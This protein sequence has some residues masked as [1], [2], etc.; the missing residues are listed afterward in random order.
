MEKIKNPIII[1]GPG[2]SGTTLLNNILGQHP[3]VYWISTYLNKFPKLPILSAL[4]DLTRNRLIGEKI[5]N[6]S[7][8]P[9]PA[10]AYNFWS[11]HLDDFRFED[12]L[13]NNNEINKVLS[14]LRLIRRY[15]SGNRFLT[16]ITG[17]ARINF[18]NSLFQDPYIIWIDR[19]PKAVI[20]SYF[21]SNWKYGVE[22]KSSESSRKD[23]IRKSIHYYNWLHNNKECLKNFRFKVCQ[24]EKLIEAPSE[25]FMEI[26]EFL[27][28]EKSVSFLKTL[29][30][31]K[32]E[33]GRNENFREV[34]SEEELNYLDELL[35]E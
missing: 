24:Y 27:E 3:D 25:F 15:Q 8:S 26:C 20:S 7:K 30:D 1:Q 35:T 10:E 18:I 12:T 17:P 33:K 31:W 6:I 9:K 23:Y 21:K 29:K 13:F 16:K 4:N 14:E 34:F 19:N 2:K 32:I 22:N 28:L 11:N 5:R